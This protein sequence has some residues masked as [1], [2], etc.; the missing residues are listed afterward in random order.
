[1]VA[2]ELAAAEGK[3]VR[4]ARCELAVSGEPWPFAERRREAIA[5]RWERSRAARPKLFDG[6][7]YL[8]GA[9]SL[10]QGA[11]TG[12]LLR[13]DFK[14]FLY[15]RECGYPEAGVR[16]GF[17]SSLIRSSDGGVLLGRQSEGN[18]NAGLAY[19]PS[20]MIDA[21]DAAGGVVDIEAS[22]MRELGEETGL[23][24][25]DLARIPGYIFTAYG[26]FVSIA[27]EW[28]SA[29]AA[30]V[31]RERILAHIRSQPVPELADA[32]IVRTREEI[33][34]GAIP[35]YAKAMLRLVLAA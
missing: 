35:D 1:M 31:L 9:C 34:D 13:T 29:L 7:V 28:R 25:R 21:R 23:E 19:P 27:I 20:G 16:D 33:G 14:S 12:T 24:P 32:V 17:G 6:T 15:W 10:R 2:E 22:I 18:L 30:E 3:S 8:L 5:E 11:F 4:I 26:P